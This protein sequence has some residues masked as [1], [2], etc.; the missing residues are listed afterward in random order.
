MSG[1]R[2]GIVEAPGYAPLPAARRLG[3]IVG[4]ALSFALS[5]SAGSL[6]ARVVIVQSSDAAGSI[7][8]HRLMTIVE[9]ACSEFHIDESA[10]PHIVLIHLRDDEARASGVPAGAPVM[11]ERSLLTVEQKREAAP[12]RF[13]VWVVG[14]S[15]DEK[16][17]G[18]VAHVLRLHLRSDLSDA[19][20]LGAERRIVRRLDATVDANAFVK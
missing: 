5:A 18:A 9:Q 3:F 11:V 2:R 16:L 17:V 4:L 14:K 8:R 15:N 7:D 13:L 20:L 19:D 1:V 6:D 10:V 12:A